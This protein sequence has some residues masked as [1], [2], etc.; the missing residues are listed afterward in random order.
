MGATTIGRIHALIPTEAWMPNP[1]ATGW[2]ERPDELNELRSLRTTFQR[3]RVSSL[4]HFDHTGTSNGPTEAISGR[5]EHICGASRWAS[6]TG[7]TIS[8]DRFSL[9]AVRAGAS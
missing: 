3:S 7:A 2:L 5:L 8:S 4:A 6:V 9:L 1:R